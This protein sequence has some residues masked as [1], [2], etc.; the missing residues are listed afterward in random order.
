MILVRSSHTVVPTG[1]PPHDASHAANE[2]SFGA[3]EHPHALQGH[4]KSQQ[5]TLIP[6]APVHG[7]PPGGDTLQLGSHDGSLI[8]Q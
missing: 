5:A 4:A 7:G 1:A 3:H 8:H 2:H 6:T